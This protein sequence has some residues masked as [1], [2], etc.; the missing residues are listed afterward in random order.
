MLMNS[1][2]VLQ[3]RVAAEDDAADAIVIRLCQDRR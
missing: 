2:S 3:R 1:C